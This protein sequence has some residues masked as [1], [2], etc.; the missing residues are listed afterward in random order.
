MSCRILIVEDHA[1]L[2]QGLRAMVDAP[3]EFAVVGD[4]PRGREGIQ[5]AIE[6]EP[7]VLLLD[8]TLPDL[9][10]LDVAQHLHRRRP[11]QK[12]IALSDRPTAL[13][14]TDALE[15]G[16]LGYLLKNT[17]REELVLALRTVSAGRRFV[18]H[19][20]AS[21]M[22]RSVLHLHQAEPGPGAWHELTS[23]ERSVFRLIAQGKTNRA[24]AECLALSPKTVEKH[25]ASLMRKLGLR[26]A[27]ELT[28]LAVDLG[29]VD[30]PSATHRGP[31][32]APEF[33]GLVLQ[34]ALNGSA[35]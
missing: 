26:S 15:A 22:V 31:A 1:L 24:T 9:G 12:I 6:L 17:S 23:R 29:L 19:E 35:A 34:P 7:D 20:L 5:K 28:L 33:E 27:V 10:G 2:S 13:E 14:A 18:S 21:E 3:P 25:R 32:A 8:L 4:A 30:R 11:E 16:C